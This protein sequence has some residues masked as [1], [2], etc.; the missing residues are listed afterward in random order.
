MKSMTGYSNKNSISVIWIS[1]IATP[2]ITILRTITSASRLYAIGAPWDPNY[3]KLMP[4][5]CRM[6]RNLSKFGPDLI[7]T[8]KKNIAEIC[9]LKQNPAARGSHGG[10]PWGSHGAPGNPWAS[11]A[12]MGP[13]GEPLGPHGA[14]GPPW[15]LWSSMGPMRPLGPRAPW[16]PWSS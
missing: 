7:R 3:V 12:P 13:H 10:A 16:G 11:W 14:H 2:I 8:P 9:A 5:P 4:R 1:S 6:I 15:A